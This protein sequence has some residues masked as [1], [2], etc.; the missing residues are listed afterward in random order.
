MDQDAQPTTWDIDPRS[1]NKKPGSSIKDPGFANQEQEPG[2]EI[3]DQGLDFISDTVWKLV[4]R[5]ILV[6]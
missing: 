5:I 2:P 3:C 1:R 4:S 6:I